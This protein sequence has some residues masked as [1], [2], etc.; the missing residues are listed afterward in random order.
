V[1]L[2]SDEIT[3]AKHVDTFN[4]KN[5]RQSLP[6]RIQK[7]LVFAKAFC[8]CKKLNGYENL[9]RQ[10]LARVRARSEQRLESFAK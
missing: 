9:A 4:A 5:P 6:L 10:S 7:A 3:Q 2:P 1:L 8:I